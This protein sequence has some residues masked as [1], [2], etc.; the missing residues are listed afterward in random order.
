LLLYAGHHVIGAECSGIA[1]SDSF[2][3]NKIPDYQKEKASHPHGARI[4]RQKSGSLPIELY[5]GDVFDL[6]TD[7]LGG[8]VDAVLDRAALVALPP[9][10]IE[11]KYLPLVTS[12]MTSNAKMHFASVLELPFPKTR[13]HRTFTRMI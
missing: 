1:C 2:I 4:V 5:E 11:D 9:C 3:E 13:L 8:E 6:S 10:H 12:L 7:V